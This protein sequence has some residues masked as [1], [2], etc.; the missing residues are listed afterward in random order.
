MKDADKVIKDIKKSRAY[1]SDEDNRAYISEVEKELE[2]LKTDAAFQ[3]LDQVKFIRSRIKSIIVS[4]NL[5]LIE[6]D[7][8]R[9]RMK[10]KADRDAYIWLLRFFSRN[11]DKEV[12]DITRKLEEKLEE[13]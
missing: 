2:Q 8:S 1:Q 7:D 4:A 6:E 13:L 11:V 5:K 9:E 12:A 3:K 10:V